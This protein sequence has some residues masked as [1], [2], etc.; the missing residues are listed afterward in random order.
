MIRSL[1]S[2]ARVDSAAAPYDTIHLKVYYPA[3]M[4]G[5]QDERMTGN[6]APRKASAP[7]PVLVFF[8]G[9]NLGPVSYTHLTLPTTD[10][11]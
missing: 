6:V 2:A 11:V 3:E 9:I 5:S 4:S 7:F 8:N 1:Y 10:L